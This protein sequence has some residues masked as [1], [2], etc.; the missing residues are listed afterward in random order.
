MQD[1]PEPITFPVFETERLVLRDIR[2][3]DA[4][5]VFAFAG[6]PVVQQWDGGPV[7]DIATVA[8]W[9]EKDHA[10]A[11]DRRMF[12]WGIT[13]KSSDTVIGRVSLSNWEKHNAHIEV[14]Y[15]LAKD[16]WRR[17]IG[18]EAVWAVVRYA[19]DGLHVHRVHA[20]PTMDNVASIR[21]LE[22]LGFVHEGTNREILLMDDGLYHSAGQYS[23]LEQEYSQA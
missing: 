6:D 10:A 1:N 3:S 21:L 4:G 23:M 2:L 16:Y 13:L 20:F 5:D 7:A 17:G 9:I 14:G 15:D 19:F 22:K 18:S 11:A 8:E 12:V